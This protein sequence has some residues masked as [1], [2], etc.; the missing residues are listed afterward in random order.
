MMNDCVE[1]H[2]KVVP[3]SM[4]SIVGVKQ[5]AQS[6]LELQWC[7]KLTERRDIEGFINQWREECFFSSYRMWFDGS[8]ARNMMKYILIPSYSILTSAHKK[9][10]CTSSPPTWNDSRKLFSSGKFFSSLGKNY[11]SARLAGSMT[12]TV[13]NSYKQCSSIHTASPLDPFT[14]TKLIVVVVLLRGKAW[15]ERGRGKLEVTHET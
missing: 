5:R 1:S 9:L 11:E 8:C 15:Q 3:C 7:V 4:G 12:I 2:E 13:A 14:P 10:C 6:N